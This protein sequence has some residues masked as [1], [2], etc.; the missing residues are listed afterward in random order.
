MISY[1]RVLERTINEHTSRCIISALNNSDNYINVILLNLHCTT[2]AHA[3]KATNGKPVPPL[4][5]TALEHYKS[6][7]L[8][9][10]GYTSLHQTGHKQL[11][12]WPAG[13]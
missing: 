10:D 1:S 2:W 5:E 7:S 11:L 4:L 6:A 9:M 12:D 13:N 8:S 3:N